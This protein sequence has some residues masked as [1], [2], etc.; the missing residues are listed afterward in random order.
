MNS[1]TRPPRL[2]RRLYRLIASSLFGAQL[3]FAAVAAQKVFSSEVAALPRGD[4]RRTLAADL[5][6]QM[7]SSLDAITILG[8]AVCVLLAFRSLPTAAPLPSTAAPSATASAAE[9]P[10][11]RAALL[12]L[13][14]GLCAL[15]SAFGTTPVI[16]SL[17]DAN[18][19]AEPL[20]GILHASSTLLLF[21][22]MLLL[23]FAS[24]LPL[25]VKPLEQ[26]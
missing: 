19:T 3:F 20:F 12:P 18:R 5:V 7:L 25:K 16:H 13:V 10:S 1:V 23:V 9:R 4:P 11:H 21:T 8:C 24:I 26:S 2:P 6:G 15:A 17:R 22:E 14:A